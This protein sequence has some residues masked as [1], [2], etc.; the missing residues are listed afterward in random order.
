MWSIYSKGTQKII[1]KRFKIFR[2]VIKPHLGGFLGL[3]VIKGHIILVITGQQHILPCIHIGND[4]NPLIN[5]IQDLAQAAA[6]R[7]NEDQPFL[8]QPL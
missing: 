2:G 8:I 4:R 6:A 7:V 1:L 5:I 3:R